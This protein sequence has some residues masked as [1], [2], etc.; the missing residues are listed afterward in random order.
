MVKHVFVKTGRRARQIFKHA[1]PPLV[2]RG[3]AEHLRSAPDPDYKY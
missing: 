3:I 1:V 2:P